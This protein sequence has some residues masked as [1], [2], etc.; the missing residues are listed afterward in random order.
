MIDPIKV[1]KYSEKILE[2]VDKKE[3]FTQ[4]DLQG[5][6]DALVMNMITEI[7]AEAKK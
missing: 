7:E 3:D 2:I 5:A 6:V 1:N 4:S